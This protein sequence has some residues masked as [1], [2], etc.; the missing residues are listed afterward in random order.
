MF[1]WVLVAAFANRAN[2]DAKQDRDTNSETENQSK[3]SFI[4]V[5][6]VL[7]IQLRDNIA[8]LACRGIIADITVLSTRLA[9]Y[10]CG[11]LKSGLARSLSR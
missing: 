6:F 1:V 4:K 3:L 7:S 10:G 11:A 5:A 8:G 2:Y 9:I